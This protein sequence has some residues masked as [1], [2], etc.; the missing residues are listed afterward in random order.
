[1]SLESSEQNKTLAII[2]RLISGSAALDFHQVYS[3]SD[4]VDIW[5]HIGF[6][7]CFFTLLKCVCVRV[8]YNDSMW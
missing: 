2:G 6:L 7:Q 4:A 3:A 1:M 5:F 8:S